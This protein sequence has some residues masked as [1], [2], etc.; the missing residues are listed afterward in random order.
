VAGYSIFNIFSFEVLLDFRRATV[1]AVPFA[2]PAVGICTCKVDA[3]RTPKP[4]TQAS[5][6]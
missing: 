2:L 1:A 6:A 3:W 5:M 4:H